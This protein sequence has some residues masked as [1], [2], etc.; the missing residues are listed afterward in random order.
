MDR[1]SSGSRRSSFA[2]MRPNYL[3]KA[4]SFEVSYR[5]DPEHKKYRGARTRTVTPKKK[6]RRRSERAAGDLASA[7]G[8][9]SRS[10][11]E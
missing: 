6:P 9:P 5:W 1:E 7:R 3:E 4:V 10:A 8:Q 11:R 2:P